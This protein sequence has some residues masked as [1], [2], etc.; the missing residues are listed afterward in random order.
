MFL[1]RTTGKEPYT[2]SELMVWLGNSAGLRK[3]LAEG[4]RKKPARNARRLTA[5]AGTKR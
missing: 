2:W 4:W 5:F 1:Y 3:L